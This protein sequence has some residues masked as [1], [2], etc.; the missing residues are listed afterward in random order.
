MWSPG[1]CVTPQSSFNTT[2][3]VT[4]CCP[5]KWC[6]PKYPVSSQDKHLKVE[7]SDP[8][9]CLC[10]CSST[11]FLV[12]P[13]PPW[14]GMWVHWR[15]S[16]AAMA[17]RVTTWSTAPKM[18]LPAYPHAERATASMEASVSTYLKGPSA[19]EW[20]KQQEAR[21]LPSWAKIQQ[22][23]QGCCD[24]SWWLKSHTI[25][26]VI[27]RVWNQRKGANGKDF[28]VLI[29]SGINVLCCIWK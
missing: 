7:F 16:W 2:F 4:S 19:G 27:D 13:G 20:A 26:F 21:A 25:P 3:P 12:H 1:P 15:L 6:S 28:W 9:V 24:A 11:S 29:L 17:T 5:Y 10:C 23:I 18:D 22:G 8:K 14:Q